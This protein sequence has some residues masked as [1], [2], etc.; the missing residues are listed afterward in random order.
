MLAQ[1]AA[2]RFQVIWPDAFSSLWAFLNV[3]NTHPD[4]L[5][6]AEFSAIRVR[7]VVQ[8]LDMMAIARTV[9]LTEA[10]TANDAEQ[11]NEDGLSGG[12]PAKRIESE[13]MGGEHDD[14][15]EDEIADEE[16]LQNSPA[17][18]ARL[19]LQTALKAPPARGRDRCNH[20]ARPAS[21]W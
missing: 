3:T 8:N 1:L 10:S 9:R 17:V 13:F 12:S 6:L 7:R 16:M 15:A 11:E 14:G 21:R 5:T 18:F 19:T 4:Q 20:Q 2:Q